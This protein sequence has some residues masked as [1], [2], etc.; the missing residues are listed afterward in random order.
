MFY[1]CRSWCPLAAGTVTSRVP[2]ARPAMYASDCAL[3]SLLCRLPSAAVNSSQRPSHPLTP[4]SRES[5]S[6]D[7]PPLLALTSRQTRSTAVNS[8][9]GSVHPRSWTP[10]SHRLAEFNTGQREHPG[11]LTSNSHRS[12]PISVTV[13]LTSWPS[14]AAS[15]ADVRTSRRSRAIRAADFRPRSHV[16]ADG[17]RGRNVRT[18]AG[19]ESLEGSTRGSA[20]GGVRIEE[21]AEGSGEMS[22]RKIEIARAALAVVLVQDEGFSE[23]H[24]KAVAR[25]VTG[26]AQFV[27]ERDADEQGAAELERKL[28][29]SGLEPRT[30]EGTPE[31]LHE[32]TSEVTPGVKTEGRADHPSVV[33]LPSLLEQPAGSPKPSS[34]V[35]GLGGNK[36]EAQGEREWQGEEAGEKEGEGEGEEELFLRLVDMLRGS[37]RTEGGGQ[38]DEGYNAQ[39]QQQQGGKSAQWQAGEGGGRGEA[40][41]RAVGGEGGVSG[42]A[43]EWVVAAVAESVGVA[44]GRA[45]QVARVCVGVRARRVW[46]KIALLRSL[47]N[48][49]PVK[50][51]Q[52]SSLS[53]SFPSDTHSSP[54]NGS[55]TNGTPTSGTPTSNT[56][57]SNSN[58]VI[59][60]SSTNP[61]IST[62]STTPATAMPASNGRSGRSEGRGDS[63]WEAAGAGSAAVGDERREGERGEEERGERGGREEEDRG[64]DSGGKGEGRGFGV[65]PVGPLIQR[66]IGRLAVIARD[67]DVL[68]QKSLGFF[69]KLAAQRRGVALLDDPSTALP[70]LVAGF[71]EFLA[72]EEESFESTQKSTLAWEE[73]SDASGNV[74]GEAFEAPQK[75]SDASGNVD[76][77]DCLEA[78]GEK[79][80]EGEGLLVK[81]RQEQV[82]G[83]LAREGSVGNVLGVRVRDLPLIINR[84]PPVLSPSVFLN[85]PV[86]ADAVTNTLKCS[87]DL[88]TSSPSVFLNAPVVADAVTNALKVPISKVPI[89]KVDPML[90]RCPELLSLTPT[91]SIAPAGVFLQAVGLTRGE[92]V[93]VLSASPSLLCRPRHQLGEVGLIEEMGESLDW[94]QEN[95]AIPSHELA[96][97]VF[98]CPGLL[99]LSPAVLH[100]KAAFLTGEVGVVAAEE[101]A[102]VVCRLPEVLTMSVNSM[103][104]RIS[105][106]YSRGFSRAD[107]AAMVVRYPP[108]LG[109][110]VAAVLRPKLDFWLEEE[111]K[112]ASAVTAGAPASDGGASGGGGV[113]GVSG[114][115]AAAAVGAASGTGLGGG[116]GDGGGG[117][118]GD[119]GGGGSGGPSGTAAAALPAPTSGDQ[120]A[121]RVQGTGATRPD[122]RKR[123]PAEAGVLER[124]AP[125]GGASLASV[126]ARSAEPTARS[127]ATGARSAATWGSRRDAMDPPVLPGEEK[128]SQEGRNFSARRADYSPDASRGSPEGPV[129]AKIRPRNAAQYAAKASR[130]LQT[131]STS[132]AV[133]APA[134]FGDGAFGAVP[135]WAS[136]L[137]DSAR[138]PARPPAWMTAGRGSAS[139]S[140]SS[141]EEREES[142]YGGGL[143]G[144]FYPSPNARAETGSAGKDRRK[145]AGSGGKKPR[146]ASFHISLS[147][148]DS[149]G[150]DGEGEVGNG[151]RVG[152][153]GGKR[154]GSLGGRGSALDAERPV[155]RPVRRAEAELG[156]V[157]R[158]VAAEVELL[159]EAEL[160]EAELGEAELGEAELGE[161]ERGEVEPGEVVLGEVELGEVELGEV[162]LGEVELGE[163][164]LGEVELGEVE[165]GEVEGKVAA[166]VEEEVRQRR[167]RLEGRLM[168]EREKG[169]AAVAAVEAQREAV[170]ATLARL[171]R[172]HWQAV[173]EMRD[174]HIRRL[175][176]EHEQKSEAGESQLRREAA[177]AEARRR[178]EIEA[179]L[180]AKQQ[181]EMEEERRRKEEE[182]R[183]KEEEERRK[184]EER[185]REVQR[186]QQEVEASRRAAQAAK[187]AADA[188]DARAAAEAKAAAVAEAKKRQVQVA[189]GAAKEAEARLTQLKAISFPHSLYFLPTLQSSSAEKF[190]TQR[191]SKVR[192]AEG[193]AKEAE[194]RLARLK[195]M[196]DEIAPIMADNA[197]KKDRKTVER[198]I[199]LLVQQI[200]AMHDQIAKKSAD[201]TALLRDPSLPQTFVA[202]TFA[203]KILSQCESQVTKLPPFAFALAQVIVN[204]SSQAPI[205]MEALMASL[206]ETCIYT[207]PQHYVFSEAS[208]ASDDAYYHDLGYREEEGEGGK[209]KMESTDAFIERMTGY[210][211]LMAAICQTLPPPG[212]AVHPFGLS[213]AWQWCARLLNH[214]PANRASATALEV[215]LKIAGYRMHLTYRSQFLK[216]L[217]VVGNEYRGKLQALNDADVAPVVN[218]IETYVGVQRYLRPPEGLEMPL[219]DKSSQL[220]A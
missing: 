106:L 52:A 86:V 37:R 119:G 208:Y 156:E 130:R 134:A 147:S 30:P 188:A 69:Q 165:P 58:P 111:E 189:E 158:K 100:G 19:G 77:E 34:R 45:R 32:I 152:G 103:R 203:S 25:N 220:R 114:G 56:P 176:Q 107:V 153:D 90:T 57:T 33:D 124:E 94:L 141:D 91:N 16:R 104:N 151:E 13:G 163:V 136:E 128:I 38:G 11:S 48:A 29:R 70:A 143:G 142:A 68:L 194:A 102:R 27:L 83:A 49:A 40:A 6:R 195:A 98:R 47:L 200:S 175:S 127:P 81:G 101:V 129:P 190:Q 212:T 75:E 54:T 171:D 85:A 21:T 117:G 51:T 78:D 185:K 82:K 205:A 53:E 160:G 166:E 182:R 145:S 173:E 169:R 199:I 170:Q 210:I 218:R 89:S 178:A 214:L 202:I 146:K 140:G 18:E 126:A 50:T 148:S 84:F 132:T 191:S 63:L 206:N 44:W 7:S 73:E 192:V 159:E 113:G 96:H 196:R 116:D 155:A 66:A 161:A 219:H 97:L 197:R 193:A 26:F 5:K 201:L 216:L 154:R 186:Q 121:R 167:V 23:D 180:R 65:A 133:A 35:E 22:L 209:K 4:R 79:V 95:L 213:H 8:G 64:H 135:C 60:T 138:S 2:L 74:D 187:A 93:R 43:A 55:L 15:V 46:E 110:S 131:G 1:I 39:R 217:N 67:D 120:A 177:A 14:H 109:Y 12:A 144:N 162:E 179:E 174:S 31:G 204:V 24:A 184:E 112:G 105:F 36:G 10:L 41:E 115:A 139:S 172:E 108:L 211:T 28:I 157:E 125:S 99:C 207:V 76:G 17:T 20:R 72:W 137:G 62:S 123:F 87:E 92:M 80:E 149:S 3:R 181:R 59:T 71:P 118:D 150:S 168:E 164:E 42:E 198:R 61:V 215:F 9:Q 183:R 122:S 88:P